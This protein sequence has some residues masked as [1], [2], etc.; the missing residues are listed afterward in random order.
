[1]SKAVV[2]LSGGLDSTVLTY[3][4]RNKLHRDVTAISFDYGQRQSVELSCART[5]CDKLGIQHH[6]ISLGFLQPLLAKV[7]SN[8]KG[9]TIDVPDVEDILGHPQPVTYVPNRN[10]LMLN[11]SVT[12]AEAIGA[13]EVYIG[14]QCHDLYGYWDTTPEFLSRVNG[15]FDL[16]REHKIKVIAPFIDW[17]KAKEIQLGTELGV[18]FEDTWTCY[19]PQWVNTDTGA[20]QVHGM[21][22]KKQVACGKCGACAERLKN[23]ELCNIV[24]PVE[25]KE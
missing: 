16:N 21:K 19:N 8:L 12:I 15:V 1:M 23:F 4:V 20:V 9:S 25:Y 14:L 13:E 10:A 18:P 17:N 22:P 11:M 2:I 24:D 5:T 6:V 3:Y 7:C